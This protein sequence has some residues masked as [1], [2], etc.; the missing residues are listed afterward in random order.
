MADNSYTEYME[1]MGTKL[2]Q[3]RRAVT[4][5]AVMFTIVFGVLY[6]ASASLGIKTYNDCVALQGVEKWD[7]LKMLLSHTM[8]MGLVIPVVVLTQYLTGA[9]V[10]AGIAMLYG[11]MGVV[12]NTSAFMMINREECKEADRDAKN[13]IVAGIVFSILLFV[14]GAYFASRK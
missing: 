13:Y 5:L 4:L 11:I 10:L 6:T 8:A 2:S 9:K 1:K 7:N 12:G 14:G 3:D